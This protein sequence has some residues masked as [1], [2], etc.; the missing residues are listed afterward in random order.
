[1]ED[2]LITIAILPYYKAEILRSRLEA[3]GVECYL[4]NVNLVQGAVASGVKVRILEEDMKEALFVMEE[5]FGKE[6]AKA[7]DSAEDSDTVLIPVDFSDYSLKAGLL[8]IDLAK[9]LKAKVVLLHSFMS[10]FTYAIPYGD[11]FIYDSNFIKT[12]QKLEEET[13]EDFEKFMEQLR[14]AVSDDDW[15]LTS[16]DYLIKGGDP[17]EDILTYSEKHTPRVI[18]MGTRGAGRKSEDLIGSVTSE[19]ISRAKVPVL[20]LPE[21]SDFT[22]LDSIKKILYATNFDNKDVVA[23]DKLMRLL[24]PFDVKVYCMHVGH[25][26]NHFWDEARLEGMKEMLKKKYA[27]CNFECN[28]VEG[29]DILISVENFIRQNEIDVLCLT[30]HKRNMI[31]RIVNP[32]IA[33]KMVFHTDTPL[34]IFHA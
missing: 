24:M 3:E 1:M 19:I 8:G 23:I 29:D 7:E 32:S 30:T 11:P 6:E 26:E 4:K 33:R 25:H 12:L 10:P 21:E 20:A 22:S 9:R 17:E 13:Q 14:K 31:S 34:L 2:K 18:V 27:G 15:E 28:L 16:P 5:M